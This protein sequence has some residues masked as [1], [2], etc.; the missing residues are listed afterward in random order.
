MIKSK[1]TPYDRESC[2]K[3]CIVVVCEEDD[4]ASEMDTYFDRDTEERRRELQ[5]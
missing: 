3:R 2:L 4:N 1:R 5:L